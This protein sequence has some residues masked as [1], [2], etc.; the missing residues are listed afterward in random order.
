MVDVGYSK[1][2]KRKPSE[3]PSYIDVDIDVLL[4]QKHDWGTI[5]M[6]Y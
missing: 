1:N 4:T 5:N 2:P 3:I 6:Y